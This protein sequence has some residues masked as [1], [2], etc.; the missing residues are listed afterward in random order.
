MAAL[1]DCI[2]CKSVKIPITR[3]YFDDAERKALLEP[4][5]TGWVVQG[6]KV[7][8]FERLFADFVGTRFAVATTSCTTALHLTLA[9]LGIRAGDE[10]VVPAFT[11]VATA[12]V[13]EML[14]ARPIFVDVRLDTFN[15]D[16]N[17]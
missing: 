1:T 14:G 6:P 16:P 2:S 12:N 10:V 11:W 3:P 4:L 17:E 13:V 7:A 15:I 9:A 5:D 8:E